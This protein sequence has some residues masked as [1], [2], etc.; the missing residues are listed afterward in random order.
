MLVPQ[1]GLFVGV[2]AA[3]GESGMV[4]DGDAE[5]MCPLDCGVHSPPLHDVP[6]SL[7]ASIGRNKSL[8]RSN[9]SDPM[10]V[11][12]PPYR[13]RRIRDSLTIK[14]ANIR[15]L[16]A[17]VSA[18]ASR[19]ANNLNLSIVSRLNCSD[20][21]MTTLCRVGGIDA[22]D[23]GG[24]RLLAGVATTLSEDAESTRGGGV[25]R[26]FGMVVAEGSPA[27]VS[28]EALGENGGVEVSACVR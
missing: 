12:A 24:R 27:R 25:G 14:S 20:D 19:A 18:A 4:A 3:A 6:D 21:C 22:P 17:S 28:W 13:S 8:V 15:T 16:S 23:G 9:I 5:L 11:M 10:V 2:P 26:A 7:L 1:F